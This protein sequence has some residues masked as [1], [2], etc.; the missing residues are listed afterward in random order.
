M[1]RIR[2]FPLNLKL[3]MDTVRTISIGETE[4]GLIYGCG[5]QESPSLSWNGLLDDPGQGMPLPSQRT[6]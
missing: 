2:D 6:N 1:F 3:S 5:S 4:D